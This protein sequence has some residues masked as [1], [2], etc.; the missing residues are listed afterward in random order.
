MEPVARCRAAVVRD[1]S[2]EEGL[3][4]PGNQLEQLD[5]QGLRQAQVEVT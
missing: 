2:S 1:S 5:P 3:E 4:V